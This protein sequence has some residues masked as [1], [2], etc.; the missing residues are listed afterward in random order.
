MF[1]RFCDKFLEEFL[2][3][4]V[5]NGNGSGLGRVSLY[6]NPTHG[7]DSEARTRPVY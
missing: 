4:I 5:R 3:L 1:V 6:P 7:S 2:L